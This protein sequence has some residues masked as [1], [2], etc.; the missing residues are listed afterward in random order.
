MFHAM[1]CY[2]EGFRTYQN[3]VKQTGFPTIQEAKL[4]AMKNAK[5]IPFVVQGIKVVWS[6][7]SDKLKGIKV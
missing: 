6:P 5:G 4:Y 1:Q 2:T 3:A 7:I